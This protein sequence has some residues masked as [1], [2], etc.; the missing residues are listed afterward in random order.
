MPRIRDI[1]RVDS[2]LPAVKG[3]DSCHFCDTVLNL[4]IKEGAGLHGEDV[5]VCTDCILDGV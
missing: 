3:Q 2:N 1:V 5:Y 4:S